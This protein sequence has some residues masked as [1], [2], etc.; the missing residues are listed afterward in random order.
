MTVAVLVTSALV[1]AYALVSG[2]LRTTPLTGPLLFTAAGLALGDSGIRAITIQGEGEIGKLL[3]ESSL[4][5]VLFS[6]AMAIS[7]TA[8]LRE[9]FLPLRLLGIGLPLTVLAG[10]GAA[11]MVLPGI[12][13]WHAAVL[14]AVLAPTDAALGQAVV[15]DRRVP[16]LIRHGLNVESGLNDGLALPFLTV[17][18][19][20][21]LAAGGTGDQV[22]PII[23][24]LRAIVFSSALGAGIAWAVSHLMIRS[25]RRGWTEPH[26]RAITLLAV[27]AS[28]YLAADGVGGSGFIAVWVAGLTA[29]TRLRGHLGDARYL[30]EELADLGTSLSFLVFGA[31][32]LG[33]ALAHAGWRALAYAALSLTLVRMAPVAIALLGRRL[34]WASVL[35]LGWFGPRGLASLI[36]AG[37]I[38][39]VELPDAEPVVATVMLTVALSVL[40][41]GLTASWGAG[42]YG[43]WY[44]VAAGRRPDLP[45]GGPAPGIDERARVSS[46]GPV[47]ERTGDVDSGGPVPT[48]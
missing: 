46:G 45:E 36:F 40:L 38:V 44:R 25:A 48:G 23:E 15:A 20:L 3:L 8:W 21:A 10:W 34:S 42:R 22:T 33:V 26:W 19:T 24:L 9:S 6:D 41:H 7:R 29:G 17:F 35:Y 39:E 5:L 43:S 1:I 37:L 12:A 11:L 2:R 32:Y 31:L 18:L 28:A 27:A 14:G 47:P 4:V 16:R 13:V 30:P